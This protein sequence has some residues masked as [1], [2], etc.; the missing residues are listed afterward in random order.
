MKM[1][2]LKFECQNKSGFVGDNFKNQ[3]PWGWQN[4]HSKCMPRNIVY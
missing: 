2:N 4:Y 3:F 1:M